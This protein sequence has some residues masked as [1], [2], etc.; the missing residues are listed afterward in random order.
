[1]VIKK[2]QILWDYTNTDIPDKFNQVPFGGNSPVASV[3]NWNTW[4]PPG[5]NDRA[6]FRPMVRV[7]DNT[8]GGE[9]AQ[10]QNSKYPIIL[11]FNEP[12]RANISPEQARD[13]WYSQMLPLRK[14]KGKQLGSPAVASD[15]NGR[16]WIEKFMS[17]VSKDPPDF[18]C[19]H[20]YS[21]N[22]NY[23][24]KYIQDMHN[25]WPNHK[26]MVTEI[27]CIDRN[28][29]VVVDFTVRI[30]NWLDSQDWVFEYGLFDFQRKVADGFVSPVAQLMDANG[31][32]TELGK[33]YVHQQP[34]KAPGVATNA[35]ISLNAIEENDS[36]VEV[37]DDAKAGEPL[38]HEPNGETAQAPEAAENGGLVQFSIAA[39][40][41]PDQQKALDIH[42][43][44]RKS[45]GLKPLAWDNQ[46]A[47]NAEDYGKHLAQIGKL[48]HSSGDQRPNQGENLAWASS[49]STPLAMSANMWIAEEKN[50][51]GEPIGQGDFGSYGH[52]T[53]CMWKST[54]KLGMG[55]AKDAKGGVYIVGRYS[56]PGNFTGQKPY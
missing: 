4:V 20:Y 12:E 13:I 3:V 53:Q 26:V 16:K 34:M 49:S 7:L 19:L 47:K 6:P 33:M 30:C 48:Q 9:W 52:Y 10:I 46:L 55:S 24:I 45:K 50:Y 54:T 28:Y 51:H 5:L 35:F 39:A 37:G 15:D 43:N 36:Q 8:K 42:N 40:L 11:Y 44:K 14:N 21:T 41:G 56:P 27:A 22:A 1:M 17:L 38:S 31:N 25:K 2:R 32:F 18:L 29:Q 23:A